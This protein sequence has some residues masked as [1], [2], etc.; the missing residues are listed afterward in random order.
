MAKE[1]QRFTVRAKE[2]EITDNRFRDHIRKY[3]R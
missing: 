2:K 1:I 3:V